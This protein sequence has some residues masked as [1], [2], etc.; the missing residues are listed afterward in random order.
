MDFL[1]DKC[2]LCCKHLELIPQLTEY[3]SGDGRCM[4]LSEDNLCKIYSSRPDIC[5]VNK[6]YELE[7]SNKMSRE[8]YILYNIKGCKMLKENYL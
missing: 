4:Y 8:E 5:N 1:C 2:G 6:M 3:N 7:Y